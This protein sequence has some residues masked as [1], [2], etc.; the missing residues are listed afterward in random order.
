MKLKTHNLFNIG[1]LTAIGSLFVNPVLSLIS[2]GILS[3]T[4]DTIIDFFGHENN[5]GVPVRTYKTH[6]P[7]RGFI[8]G[9]L[10]AA[11]LFFALP[12]LPKDKFNF[13]P[14]GVPYWI[15]LQGLFV[16]PLHLSMDVITEGGI[17]IKKNGRFQRYAIAHINYSSFFWNGLFQLSGIAIILITF[18]KAGGQYSAYLIHLVKYHSIY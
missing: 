16:G 4:G 9:A 10:P 1:I 6:S 8:W 13:I 7:L 3:V 5:Y 12:H 11:L 14:E 18:Y 17:F 15:L 2:A